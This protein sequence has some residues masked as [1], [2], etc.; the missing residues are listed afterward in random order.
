MGFVQSVN[1]RVLKG[2]VQASHIDL[3]LA[4]IIAGPEQIP[5]YPVHSQPLGIRDVCNRSTNGLKKNLE[6]KLKVL[7]KT[8]FAELS[9]TQMVGSLLPYYILLLQNA[10]NK[11]CFLVHLSPNFI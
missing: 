3:L 8:N 9:Q 11:P 5:G 2:A 4:G 1:D 6:Q 7:P 10:A